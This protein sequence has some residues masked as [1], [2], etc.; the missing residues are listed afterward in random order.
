[1][2]PAEIDIADLP[3]R[4]AE[5]AGAIGLAATLALVEAR[6]GTRLYIPERAAPEHWLARTIGPDAFRRLAADYAGEQLEIDRAAGAVRAARD[7]AI[8]A[9]ADAGASTAKLALDYGLTQ[10]QI[11][12][13]LAR[14]ANN[15]SPQA[16]LF[17]TAAPEALQP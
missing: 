12:T 2:M 17:H 16:D 11:F 7:R 6:G 4:L 8:R 9:A 1:M 14:G 10:R 5:L 15:D 13:I 3:P